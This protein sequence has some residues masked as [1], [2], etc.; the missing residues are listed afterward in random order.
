MA[1][2]RRRFG[3]QLDVRVGS[4]S[5]LRTSWSEVC[6]SPNNGHVATVSV[7]PFRDDTVAKVE[8]RTK[9]KILRKLIL[10]LFYCCNTRYADTGSLWSFSCSQVWSLIYF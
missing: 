10:R 3:C 8:N 1:C 4:N 5:D 2:N 7:C 9:P 6:L